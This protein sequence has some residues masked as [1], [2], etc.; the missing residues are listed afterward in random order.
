M[1]K[2]GLVTG[3][4]SIAALLLVWQLAAAIVGSQFILP[5]PA[6][7]LRDLLLLPATSGFGKMIGYT[8]VRG[9]TAFMIALGIA[10]LLGFPSGLYPSFSAALRPWMSV[11]KAT[12]VVSIILLALFW[13]GSATVPVF[14][15][16]LMTVPVLT[17]AIA[18]GV[19]ATDTKLLEMAR[20]YHLSRGKIFYHI[21]I[22]SALPFFISGA[23]SALGLTWKVVVAG[24]ILAMPRFGLG[25]AMQ[26][27]KIYLE[28]TRVFSL[29][30]TAILL[31]V[32][33]EFIFNQ[34]IKLTHSQT[35]DKGNT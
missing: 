2:Q 16:V 30:L 5:L 22:P 1:K 7:V 19:R 14:V 26:S 10:C 25:S 23:S 21:H 33:T 3:A 12:P 13:F 4:V 20:A 27:A 17:E 11:I 8:A 34:T 6:R 31:C 32:F 9:L 15:A 18:Q 35:S 28:T 29:T 24:E